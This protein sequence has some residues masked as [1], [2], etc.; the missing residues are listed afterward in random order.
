MAHP[1]GSPNT[2]YRFS[3]EEM[4]VLQQC[5]SESF[6]Q[7]CLPIGTFLGVTTYV[8]VKSGYLNANPKFGA[9]PK[10]A[11]A[12]IMG[13]IMGKISYQ[14][15]C[16]E[17]LMALPDSKIGAA[18]RNKKRGGFLPETL[19]MDGTDLDKAVSK[20]P[21]S[22]TYSDVNSHSFLDTESDRPMANFD[23]YKASSLDETLPDEAVHLPHP[24]FKK[25]TTYDELRK[26]NREEFE[27][28]QTKP[29]RGVLSQEDIPT[30]LK[31]RE[32]RW[33]PSQPPP[34]PTNL[35]GDVWD[36]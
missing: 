18:L 35:Y 4:R 32:G 25:G 14:S 12:V 22:D 36:K 15:V 21:S 3:N 26:R 8:G 5:N 30:A 19:T 2:P 34:P 28:K 31:E 20:M 23:S 9:I 13:Y 17:K 7:R 16:A 33:P 11:A 10:V 6:F 1:D 29:Y 27:N 24:S